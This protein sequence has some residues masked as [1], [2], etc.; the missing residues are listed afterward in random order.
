NLEELTAAGKFR[1]DLLYRL[2][3]ITL[4]MPALRDR[5]SDIPVL[6]RHFIDKHAEHEKTRI[7]RAALDRLVAFPWPGNVRQL[8]NE[9]RRALVLA[10]DTIDV[11]HLSPELR[12]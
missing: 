8:E 1:Q 2:N 3:V 12:G 10:D 11:E 7:S 4:A 6:V 5:P 9:I